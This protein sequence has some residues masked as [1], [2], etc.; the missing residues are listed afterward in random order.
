MMSTRALIGLMVLLTLV[1]LVALE[2]V[3]RRSWEVWACGVDMILT[4]DEARLDFIPPPDQAKPL[5][6][7]R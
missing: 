3:S 4:E 6:C 7:L 1:W 2:H 5:P